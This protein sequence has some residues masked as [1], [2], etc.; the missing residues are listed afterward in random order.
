[1][2]SDKNEYESSLPLTAKDF[3]P[4]PDDPERLKEIV[5]EFENDRPALEDHKPVEQ[6]LVVQPAVPAQKKVRSVPT[7]KYGRVACLGGCGLMVIPSMGECRKCRKARL[8][9]GL[10]HILKM[11]KVPA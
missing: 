2:S 10:K 4:L 1:M 9:S 8:R 5:T 6:K 3:V 11:K 7:G